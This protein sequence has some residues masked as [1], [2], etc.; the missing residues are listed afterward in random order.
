[1]APS[2]TKNLDSFTSVLDDF[3]KPRSG[4]KNKL[5]NTPPYSPMEFISDDS[6]FPIHESKSSNV[7]LQ[8]SPPRVSISLNDLK[9]MLMYFHRSSDPVRRN[10]NDA[11]MTLK[12]LSEN[13]KGL[14]ARDYVVG[15]I[16]NEQGELSASYPP[17]ILI[18]EGELRKKGANNFDNN[19]EHSSETI[20][21]SSSN[22]GQKTHQDNSLSLDDDSQFEMSFLETL[23]VEETEIKDNQINETKSNLKN[24]L[25]A[26]K[27]TS[28][29]SETS[30]N[31]I[32]KANEAS[33]L[34]PLFRK[35]RFA[36]VRNRF[37]VPVIFCRGKNICRSGTLSNG[38]EVVLNTK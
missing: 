16:S 13:C 5:Q 2:A 11:L 20:I 34:G 17:Y 4:T 31:D 23:D 28:Q 19:L 10:G 3:Q 25:E 26:K 21:P 15:V 12:L 37:V 38:A 36:R 30:E 1:M 18:I 9:T 27:Y 29:E 32:K 24:D 35:C 7:T 22:K 14:L 6:F 33:T 8:S